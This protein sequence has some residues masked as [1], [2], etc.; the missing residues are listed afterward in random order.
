MPASLG[1]AKKTLQMMDG[2]AMPKS[3]V[4]F[5]DKDEAGAFMYF[6]V[7]NLSLDRDKK[8][9]AFNLYKATLFESQIKANS[10]AYYLI[11]TC[12]EDI[13]AKMAAEL[14]AK[15]DAKKVSDAEDFATADLLTDILRDLDKQLWILEAHLEKSPSTQ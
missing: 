10:A 4:P 14:K 7:G 8:E 9:A 2:G 13:Y 11:A 3:F 5:K 12:Y 15:I 1:Y 6:V